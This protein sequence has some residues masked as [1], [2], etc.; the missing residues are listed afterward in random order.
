MF[1]VTCP[2]A[3]ISIITGVGGGATL[4]TDTRL[5]PFL[6][7]MDRTVLAQGLARRRDAG[8]P[9]PVVASLDNVLGNGDVLRARVLDAADGI[10]ATLA[11]WIAGKVRAVAKGV[12]RTK[13]RFGARLTVP[14]VAPPKAVR[15]A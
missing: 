15:A 6:S 1:I 11:D 7:K 2:S 9:A 4:L 5:T 13:S 12:R 14:P 8:L 3:E 10:D